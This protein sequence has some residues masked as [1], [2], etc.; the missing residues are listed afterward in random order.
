MLGDRHVEHLARRVGDHRGPQVD[1]VRQV[2]QRGTGLD[3][4]SE[5]RHRLP[6]HHAAAELRRV[7][8]VVPKVGANVKHEPAVGAALPAQ[9]R[10]VDVVQG[11]DHPLLLHCP[12]HV[13]VVARVGEWHDER[14]LRQRPRRT[15]LDGAAAEVGD[16]VVSL[17][18]R[19]R[20]RRRAGPRGRHHRRQRRH[21]AQWRARPTVGAVGAE[22]AEEPRDG[23]RH[24]SHAVLVDSQPSHQQAAVLAHAVARARARVLAE[25]HA[26]LARPFLPLPPLGRAA[27]D[28]SLGTAATALP[29]QPPVRRLRAG[30]GA[31]QGQQ[32]Q[33]EAPRPHTVHR[34]TS[35]C[36]TC[37]VESYK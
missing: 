3:E 21:A 32:E 20:P 6:R 2:V 1:P 24:A 23:A 25:W 16:P 22:V 18:M 13:K 28:A 26:V 12:A 17:G 5:H 9:P 30:A 11:L 37:Q 19:R 31:T 35:L 15:D 36:V 10:P 29:A 4:G 8:R 14:R 27:V 7:Q 34:C 33:A